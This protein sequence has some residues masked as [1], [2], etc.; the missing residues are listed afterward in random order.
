MPTVAEG[1]S[2]FALSVS[3]QVVLVAVIAAGLVA[4]V[5]LAEQILVLGLIAAY[6]ATAVLLASLASPELAFVAALVGIFISVILQFTAA[7]RRAAPVHPQSHMPLAFRALLVVLLLWIAWSLGL[8]TRPIDTARF[9]TVWLLA[10]A[11]LAL[12]TSTDTFKVGVSLLLVLAAAL[13][14]F[15]TSVAGASIFV[16]GLVCTA[17]FAISLT[18]SQMALYRADGSVDEH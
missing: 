11:G 4:V 15:A 3:A 18:T 13:L 7:E 2:S 14:Y 8:F 5:A 17:A 6:L 12:A 1:I 9:A 10:S 16:I